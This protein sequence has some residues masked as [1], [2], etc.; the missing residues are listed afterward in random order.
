[1]DDLNLDNLAQEILVNLQ[2]NATTI[3]TGFSL[4]SP[5]AVG[6]AVQDYLRDI[7]LVNVLSNFGIDVSSEFGRR[8]MED[9]AFK[10]S[11]G[12]Y[13]AVDVKTQSGI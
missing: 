12:N 10:D 1:M 7:G 2:N 4:S 9:M 6:D 3:V 13:Y 11:F 8:S 5:R